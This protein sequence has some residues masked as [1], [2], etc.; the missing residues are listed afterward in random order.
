MALADA[1]L[2]SQDEVSEVMSKTLSPAEYKGPPI[3]WTLEEQVRQGAAAVL[4]IDMQVD[5]VADNGRLA[6][7]GLDM[8][9]AQRIIPQVNA[10]V[11]SARAAKVPVV[12]VRTSHRFAD[13]PPP[14]LA[15]YAPGGRD[16]DWDEASLPVFEGSAGA[17]WHPDI[18]PRR[19]D[20]V[21]VV[22]RAYSAFYGTPLAQILAAH[23][24]Q[25][26][27]LAGVNTN[28]CI[29]T[30]AADAFFLGL[31]PVLCSDACAT[32]DGA[33]HDAFMA[34]HRRFYGL[35]PSVAELAA[36]W[37]LMA[38]AVVAKKA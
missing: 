18:E 22:K 5:F 20:E 8:S 19:D 25:T 33:I 26:V 17:E 32:A 6:R 14:Y 35:T 13:S 12:W 11:R 10:L 27:I 24:I 15:I 1:A 37:G 31:Y 23:G 28:V 9:A 16:G 2:R 21:E 7:R 3:R 4:V 34:T 38:G 30:T 36:A 29:H